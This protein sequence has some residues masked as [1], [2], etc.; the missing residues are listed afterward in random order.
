MPVN[1]KMMAAM[2]KEYGS[3]KGENVYYAMENK[4]TNKLKQEWKKMPQHKKPLSSKKH[5]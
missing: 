5:K 3:K 1:K 2:K 4:T